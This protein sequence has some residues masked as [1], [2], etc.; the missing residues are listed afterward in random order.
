METAVES[1]QRNVPFFN[2]P[3]V[4]KDHREHFLKIFD[5]VCSRGAFIMQ[6]ELSTFE[7]NLARFAGSRYAI[8]VA[9]A[10]DALQMLLMAAGIKQGD[11]VIISSHTMVATA[12]A[13]HFAGGIP[14]PVDVGYDRLID[15]NK[16]EGAITSKT[17]AIMPTQLNGRVAEMDR[18]KKIADKNNLLIFEDSAQALGAKFDGVSAGNFGV[19]GCIS[20]YPAKVLGCFGDGGAI[21]CND[22]KIYNHLL[23]LRDHG[24]DSNGEVVVWGVNSRLDNLQAA[25]LDYGLSNYGAVI[26]RRREMAQ[27]YH[28]GLSG[29]DELVLPPPP[30]LESRHFDIF[31]NYE[32]QADDRNKLRDHLRNNGIGSLVQWGGYPVHSFK[33]LGFTQEL[34][35]TD[36]LFTK[37]LMIPL[38]MSVTDQDIEYVCDKIRRFYR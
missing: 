29:I 24:R 17:K 36:E 31:Q 6:S 14:V 3:S 1:K 25:F 32:I 26:E 10:T 2:Y 5:D 38:N 7:T 11:E 12:S 18:I 8:G 34:K 9:N 19:G 4:Y 23:L 13:I 22:E 33:K 21:L 30:R 16:I 37:F 27:I 28:D 20:F 35:H 15:V